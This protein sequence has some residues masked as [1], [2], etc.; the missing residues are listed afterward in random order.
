MSLYPLSDQPLSDQPLSKHRARCALPDSSRTVGR[1]APRFG[2]RHLSG[3]AVRI[4][5][6]WL[7]C[8]L[9]MVMSAT[10]AG[11]AGPAESAQSTRDRRFAGSKGQTTAEYA[12]VL[13]GAATVAL[14]VL[15]WAANSGKVQDLLDRVFDSII[16]KVT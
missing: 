9:V 13:L 1:M 11:T 14:L 8:W 12:L 6:I 16:S 2:P 5:A 7:G 4:A 15:A 3:H 10:A